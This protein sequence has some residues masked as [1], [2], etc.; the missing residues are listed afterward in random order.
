MPDFSMIQPWMWFV[1]GLALVAAEIVAPGLFLFWLGLAAAAVALAS[2]LV[3]LS[4]HWQFILF[5]IAALAFV[6]VGRSLAARSRTTDAPH[7]NERGKAMIGRI[8]ILHEP[9]SAGIGQVKVDDSV[10]RVTGPDAPR[11]SRVEV[12]SINGATLEVRPL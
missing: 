2:Y 3:E 7:L 11:G 12:T 5:A 9:I 8:L 10:W 1:L 6:F 4:W